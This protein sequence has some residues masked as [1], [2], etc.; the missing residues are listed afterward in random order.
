MKCFWVY[1]LKCADGSYY[2]GSTSNL[3]GR[4]AQLNAGVLGGYTVSRLPVQLVFSQ[5]FPQAEEAVRAERQIKNWSRKKK[6]A[7]IA[8]DFEL[9]HELARCRN[10]TSHDLAL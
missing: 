4:I 2:T 3:E 1:I 8:R 10:R 9:L 7:L 6:V 5:G